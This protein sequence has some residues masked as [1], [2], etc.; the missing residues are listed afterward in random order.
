M[1]KKLFSR[2]EN[3]KQMATRIKIECL[4]LF[5]DL[6]SSKHFANTDVESASSPNPKPDYSDISHSDFGKIYF[7][8]NSLRVS[9]L[10]TISNRQVIFSCSN[11]LLASVNW[12]NKKA[13]KIKTP[14]NPTCWEFFF[15]KKYPTGYDQLSNENT[16]SFWKW[17]KA[18]A[19]ETYLWIVLVCWT[20][21]GWGELP[22]L[23][24]HLDF[25]FQIL[26]WWLLLSVAEGRQRLLRVRSWTPPAC[27]KL[28]SR[29][30]MQ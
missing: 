4:A 2:S 5:P 12:R 8:V 20:L 13:Q 15:K 25:T 14:L 16:K 18:R 3:W 29:Q 21:L 11:I 7:Q 24:F 23:Y 1:L 26:P 19:V 28:M 22:K 30:K 27:W 6:L 9:A 10:T 17:G